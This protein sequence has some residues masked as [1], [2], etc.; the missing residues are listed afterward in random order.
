MSPVI[1][2]ISGQL[3]QKAMRIRA[4][5][6]F[7]GNFER[8]ITCITVAFFVTTDLK[9]IVAAI[10]CRGAL[11]YVVK[12]LPARSVAPSS[13]SGP[14]EVDSLQHNERHDKV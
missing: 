12:Y 11:T 8:G 3:S 1:H 13:L 2:S 7:G 6:H 5:E 9:S 14:G 10:D 4:C